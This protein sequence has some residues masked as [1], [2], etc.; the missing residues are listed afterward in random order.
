MSER[1]QPNAFAVS[2]E[3]YLSRATRILTRTVSPARKPPEARGPAT[4]LAPSRE[5]FAGFWPKT[6]Y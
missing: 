3:R 4:T 2:T 6:L 1:E 5:G